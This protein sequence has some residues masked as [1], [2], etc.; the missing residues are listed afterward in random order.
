MNKVEAL[1][2]RLLASGDP[3]ANLETLAAQVQTYPEV[4]RA[5]VGKR[6][7]EFMIGAGA[8][9]SEFEMIPKG[10]RV[11][12]YSTPAVGGKNWLGLFDFIAAMSAALK[13]HQQAQP[14]VSEAKTDNRATHYE[15][16]WQNRHYQDKR[17]LFKGPESEKNRASAERFKKKLEDNDA[18]DKYGDIRGR[19]TIRAIV[20]EPLA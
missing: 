16:C 20:P 5:V 12:L 3:R 19:V 14:R 8:N 10:D 13:H 17:Q 11:D 15:V 1:V 7:V 9:C 6:G 2:E 18:K 4:K